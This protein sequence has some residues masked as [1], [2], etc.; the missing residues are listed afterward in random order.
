MNPY[1]IMITSLKLTSPGL[2]FPMMVRSL[3]M[4]FSPTRSTIVL[5]MAISKK[6][7]QRVNLKKR[8]RKLQLN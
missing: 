8:K 1:L 3:S 4:R 6:R 7:P 2:N 5:K